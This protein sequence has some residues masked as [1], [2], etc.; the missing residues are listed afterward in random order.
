[1]SQCCI[2]RKKSISIYTILYYIYIAST[3]YNFF[4]QLNDDSEVLLMTATK[5]RCRTP[6]YHIFDMTRYTGSKLS[7]KS[8]NYLGKI[9]CNFNSTELTI[10]G[11]DSFDDDDDSSD[12]KKKNKDILKPEY[13]AA[14]FFDVD[15]EPDLK[16]AMPRYIEI[17]LPSIAVNDRVIPYQPKYKDETLLSLLSDKGVKEGMH[18][19]QVKEPAY[20]NGSYRLNF[21]GRVNVSSVKNFQLT[22]KNDVNKVIFQF[23]KVDDNKF[24]LDFASPFSPFQAF[25]IALLQFLY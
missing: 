11:R 13:G 9:R 22:Y 4:I 23:G 12:K 6:N 20:K 14:K 17:V 7:K 2:I 21:H 25:S 16:G 19:L 1:M 18:E 24:N 10:Y 5:Q 3:Q 8:G 15:F